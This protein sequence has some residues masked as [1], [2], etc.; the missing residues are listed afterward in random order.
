MN[1]KRLLVALSLVVLP[2]AEISLAADSHGPRAGYVAKGGDYFSE[3]VVDGS[4]G[5]RV[6]IMDSQ[7][8]DIDASGGKLIGNLN[9]PGSKTASLTC[10][11]EE[12]AFYCR[13]PAAAKPNANPADGSALKLSFVSSEK[14]GGQADFSYSFPLRHL[15][16]EE[17]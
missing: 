8:R 16:T 1:G 15:Q 10:G 3:I 14:K 5:Y 7:W 9:G 11:H 12:N 2:S 4:E 13:Y 17:K 6:Y